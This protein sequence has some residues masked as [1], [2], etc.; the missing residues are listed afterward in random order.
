MSIRFHLGAF[1][2]ALF[3]SSALDRSLVVA[4]IYAAELLLIIP[5]LLIK[6]TNFFRSFLS[7]KYFSY[8]LYY[9]VIIVVWALI[10]ILV[11]P[12]EMTKLLFSEMRSL[13]YIGVGYF[14]AAFAINRNQFSKLIKP[15]IY[16]CFW[17]P[18]LYL[19]ILNPVVISGVPEKVFPNVTLFMLVAV[20]LLLNKKKVEYIALQA[21]WL[22]VFSMSLFRSSLATWAY[23]LFIGPILFVIISRLSK[24]IKVLLVGAITFLIILS[25]EF[26]SYYSTSEFFSSFYSPDSRA[27]T[28]IIHKL[29]NAG[30]IESDLVRVENFQ[31]SF[32]PPIFPTPITYGSSFNLKDVDYNNNFDSGY[33][34]FSRRLGLL[35]LLVLFFFVAKLA[36]QPLLLIGIGIPVLFFFYYSGSFSFIG[37]LAASLGIIIAMILNSNIKYW[38]A[39]G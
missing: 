20:Y 8:L 11:I 17:Y 1:F 15:F 24:Y 33:L 4:N 36:S 10:S 22:P 23:Y 6:N 27:Q 25:L 28:Q 16:A 35:Y 30:T 32:A 2:F 37:T 13:T 19:L 9:I 38:M 3:L 31:R 29:E 21:L 34:Y 39:S 12:E 26:F 5:L 14:T 18:V 7:S